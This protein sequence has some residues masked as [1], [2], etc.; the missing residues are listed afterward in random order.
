MIAPHSSN[1]P[2][3]VVFGEALTDLILQADGRW[4][5]VP[6]GS[7]W[8]VA[9]VAARLG[10]QTGFAGAVSQDLFGDELAERSGAAGLDPRFLQRAA[11][12]PL[13][14]IVASSNPP[15]YFFVGDSSADLRFAAEALPAGWRE[16]V[17]IVHFGGISLAREPL[18]SHLLH[19]A[20]EVRSAGKKIAFDPNFRDLMRQPGYQPI[21]RT[22]AAIADYIKVSEEDLSGLFPASNAIAALEQLRQLAPNAEI[23]LT[24]GSAG[25]TLLCVD[26]VIEQEAFPVEPVDTVG[27]GDAAMG[28]WMAS[29]MLRPGLGRAAHLRLAA[30]TAALTATHAGPYAP[31]FAEV[32]A[33]LGQ[34]GSPLLE[35]QTPR[36]LQDAL[37][38]FEK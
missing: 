31:S 16:A 8:N 27:C 22:L 10:V 17:E 23:L 33:W 9:R 15:H 32:A 4:L 30:A 2:R 5:A 36:D 12:S 24:R 28:A 29:L 25:M 3:Y 35:G 6:G 37:P 20:A 7:C 21:F 11:A 18:A 1:L 34:R 13:L 26:G 14:A 19:M 38:R